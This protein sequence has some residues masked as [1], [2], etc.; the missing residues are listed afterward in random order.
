MRLDRAAAEA[1]IARQV[2]RPLG[3]SLERAAYGIV[4]IANANMERAIRVSSAERGY[5][6][7]DFTLVAFGGAGP[8]HAAALARALGFPQ[9]LVPEV[10]GAFSALG[11]LV[12]DIRHDFVRSRLVRADALSPA[13]LGALFDE[14]EAAGL[15]Q[16]REDGLAEAEMA[17]LRSA[18]L[19]Y[20]GQA[21][22]VNVPVASGPVSARTMAE[23]VGRFHEEH[24]RMFAH[25]A[26]HEPVEFVS[27][28]VTAVGRIPA[29]SIRRVPAPASVAPP[30]PHERRPVYFEEGDGFLECPVYERS[31][32]AAGMFVPGPAIVEQMDS[33]TLV[34]PEQRFRVDEFRH[35]IIETAA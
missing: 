14:L 19:R 27:I 18:D 31:G 3:L 22:E 28:R 2:G 26:P 34:H 5:D 6:P 33:T 20:V 17:L 35:L 13:D 12:A 9:V 30:V 8:L 10:P 24:Q 23:V 16:L 15:A 1:A 4:R 29:P 7:R 25:A 21:Y 32:L 11:L